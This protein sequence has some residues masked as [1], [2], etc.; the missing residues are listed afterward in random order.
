MNSGPSVVR[1]VGIFSS[2]T[3]IG[4]ILALFWQRRYLEKIWSTES[5]PKGW[6]HRWMKAAVGA[7]LIFAFPFTV[8]PRLGI[9]VSLVH[10][11]FTAVIYAVAFVAFM[12][13]AFF[14]TR[15]VHSWQYATRIRFAYTMLVISGLCALASLYYFAFS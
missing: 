15:S 13:V 10:R 5:M 1:L 9:H 3:L 14:V 6:K 4:A 11:V 8:E 2:L 7:L 12:A